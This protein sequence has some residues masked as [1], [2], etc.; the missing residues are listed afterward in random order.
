MIQACYVKDLD[1]NRISNPIILSLKMP[2]GRMPAPGCPV[3]ASPFC[4]CTHYALDA[5]RE[6]KR[7]KSR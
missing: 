4:M 2:I 1:L 3:Q 7:K 5:R 6:A